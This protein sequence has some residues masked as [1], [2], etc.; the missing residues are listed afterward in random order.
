VSFSDEWI[1][2][3]A[4]DFSAFFGAALVFGLAGAFALAFAGALALAFG[5]AA[6]FLAGFLAVGIVSP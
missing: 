3:Q 5:L 1:A 6:G 2:L 4:G